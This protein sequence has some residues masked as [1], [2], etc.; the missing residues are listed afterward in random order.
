[1]PSASH[2][3]AILSFIASAMLYLALA[4]LLLLAGLV[5]LQVVCRDI[6]DLGLPWA[7]ELSRFCGLGLVFL[8]MPRLLLDDKH[9]AMDLLPKMLPRKAEAVVSVI[10]GLLSLA[11]CGI[12]FWALYKFLLRAA[13]FATPAMGIPNLV[14]YAPAILGFVVF[15]AVAVYLIFVPRSGGEYTV[16]PDA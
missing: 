7:D 8:A 2:V 12:M 3:R 11:F 16:E 5:V 15:A 14:F 9:V 13:K 6:F 4:L 10:A 1:M